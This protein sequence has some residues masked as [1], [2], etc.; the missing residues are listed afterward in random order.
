MKKNNV[1]EDGYGRRF[2]Y[3]RLSVTDVCN[4]RCDYCLPEGY[5]S[6]PKA[7]DLSVAEAAT[8]MRAFAQL[9]TQKVRLSGGEPSL[10]KDLPELIQAARQTPGIQRVAVTSNGYKLPSVIDSWHLSGLDQLNISIDSLDDNEFARITGHDCLPKIRAGIDRALALGIQTKVNAVLLSD[11]AQARLQQ[12]LR[13]LKTTPVTL[14]FIE[15][16]QTGD[17]RDY[18]ASNHLRGSDIEQQLIES[19]WQL[20]PRAIDAGPAREYV[21]P[22][23]AGRIGLITPYSKDFCSSCNR[24]RISAQGK[25]HLCLFSDAGLDLRETIRTGDAD[26]LA[27]KVRAL[28]GNKEVSH[29]LQNGNTGG[30]QNLSIIGG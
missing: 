27:E 8:V 16:M 21:H 17:N 6:V 18:F 20:L 3:L 1:L 10:R 7:P 19:G 15:L 12:F 28:I 25:L 24:L 14:R 13:W 22:D 2:Y 5:Q 30:T 26:A 29:Y 4:F 11:G 23:Y 9:G